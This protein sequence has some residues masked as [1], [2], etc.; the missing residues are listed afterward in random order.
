MEKYSEQEIN[1]YMDT[2]RGIFDIVRL[3]DPSS[4]TCL[5]FEGGELKDSG[6]VCHKFWNR[7][8]R[9][10]N[11]VSAR[12]ISEERRH[13]KV[14]FVD[15][16]A[17]FVIS[18][19]MEVTGRVCVMECLIEIK[20]VIMTAFGQNMFRHQI[21]KING[22]IYRDSL[23]GVYNRRYYDEIAKGL[24]VSAAAFIDIDNFKA[25]NDEYGHEAGDI[26]LKTVAETV[27]AEIRGTDGM[28]RYGG[29]EFLLYF[30]GFKDDAVFRDKLR[31]LRQSVDDLVFVGHPELNVSVSI[32][33]VF[34]IKMLGQLVNDADKE[35][36][37]AKDSEDR[38]SVLV[39]DLDEE[40]VRIS[41]LGEDPGVK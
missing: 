31:S 21:D 40:A 23:T 34:D 2:L 1:E 9:C 6:T 13:T 16:R 5:E 28:I 29:D 14:E 7:E 17:Y 35:M 24:Y 39:R 32:G 36:Y 25:I 11:C 4:L 3:V 10:I 33:G 15:D 18:D 41:Q 8:E 22:K 19:P 26:V 37:V 12:A 20:D 30:T 38:I 27:N